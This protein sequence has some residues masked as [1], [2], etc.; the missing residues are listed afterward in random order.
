MRLLKDRSR[1]DDSKSY[2]SE[3]DFFCPRQVFFGRVRSFD[4]P[5]ARRAGTKL[6]P[7]LEGLGKCRGKTSTV[8]A[9]HSQP[10]VKRV[11]IPADPAPE[12]DDAD[13]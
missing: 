1:R 6:Q 12:R 13:A 3:L 8:G 10:N 9:A 5:E 2:L 4:I 7:S 11:I